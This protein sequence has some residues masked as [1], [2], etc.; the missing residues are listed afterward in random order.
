MPG[1]VWVVGVR[2]DVV[3]RSACY[4]Y[5]RHPCM[6]FMPFTDVNF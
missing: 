5:W 6:R 4:H 1:V 3:E 2:R